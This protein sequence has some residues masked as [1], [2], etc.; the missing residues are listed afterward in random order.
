ML[1]RPPRTKP[2]SVI[3]ASSASSIARLDG[4]DTAATSGTPASHA[5]CRI[6]NEVRPLTNS[7]RSPAGSPPAS[8]RRPMILSTALCRPTSSAVSTMSPSSVHS[9]A[10]CR[11]PVAANVSWSGAR[12]SGS[13]RIA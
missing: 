10:A 7:S 8:S 1:K 3:P 4:A 6:S 12:R 11:P 9:A 5:F 2:I 13:A